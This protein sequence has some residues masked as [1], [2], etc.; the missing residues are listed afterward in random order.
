VDFSAG[1]E[2]GSVI[3]V[4]DFSDGPMIP[5]ERE[6]EDR[7]MALGTWLWIITIGFCLAFLVI[8]WKVKDKATSSYAE[9]VIGG[10]SLPFFL[11][12]FTQFA[13][14]MGVGNFV[15]HAASGARVG[16]PHMF[17]ILG[18][19]GSKIIFALFFA[20][21]AGRFT[22][23]TVSEMMDDLF[24]RDRVTRMLVGL[25]ASL[26]MIAW[27]GGQGKAF[28][29]I[30]SVITG[31]NPTWIIL[32]FSAVSSSTPPS[33]ASIPWCGPTS[34]RAFSCSSSERCST[35]TPSLPW[36][37]ASPSWRRSS[38]RVDTAISGRW[39]T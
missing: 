24:V 28:G 26:I 34:S 3:D 29:H 4:S 11:I 23:K 27:G 6:R 8:S 9:Y 31:A 16:L 37:S 25:V 1:D 12:F 30:F 33:A 10:G 17:F 35:T 13:T 15:G 18:E 21:L 19:Q 39:S 38:P 2:V 22:Y 36:I 32:F 14:I 7:L 20:G 5:G